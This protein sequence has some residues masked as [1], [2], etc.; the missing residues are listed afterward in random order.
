MSSTIGCSQ[1]GDTG[2]QERERKGVETA[3]TP[4][5][6]KSQAHRTDAS[7]ADDQNHTDSFLLFVCSRLPRGGSG[8][9]IFCRC[10]LCWVTLNP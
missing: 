4:R 2:P 1:N 10:P 5:R 7:D 3:S 8:G 6:A 9:A